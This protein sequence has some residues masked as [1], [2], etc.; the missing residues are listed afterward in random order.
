MEKF[1]EALKGIVG[2]TENQH[3]RKKLYDAFLDCLELL[4]QI[5]VLEPGRVLTSNYDDHG[6]P[7]HGPVGIESPGL[8]TCSDTMIKHDLHVACAAASTRATDRGHDA[9]R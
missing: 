1:Q 6:L 8:G 2:R 4:A 5:Q 7:N 9:S 3:L